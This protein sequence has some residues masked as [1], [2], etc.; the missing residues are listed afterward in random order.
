MERRVNYREL[1]CFHRQSEKERNKQYKKDYFDLEQFPTEQMQ[2]EVR[3]FL[4]DSGKTKSFNSMRHYFTYLNQ[5]ARFLHIKKN[6]GIQSLL[7]QPPEKWISSLKGW[8][9]EEGKPRTKERKSAYGNT[10]ILDADLILFFKQIL[11]YLQP[12][13]IRDEIEKDV[14]ELDKLEIAVRENPIYHVKTISFEKIVQP[15]MR[16]EIK[17][18]IYQHLSCEAIATIQREL[19]SF[20]DFSGFLKKKFPEVESCQDIDRNV[21][22]AYLIHKMTDGK[23]GKGNS[24]TILKLRA[25]LET[26]GKIY[27]YDHLETLFLNT[28]IPPE[29]QPEF[30]VYSDREMETL[31]AHIIQ[32]DEQIARCMIIHQM[33]GTRISDTLTLRTDCIY[34]TGDQYMIQ[35]HQVKTNTYTKPISYELAMLLEQSIEYTKN[36]YGKTK[37]IF[38]DEKD[39]SRPLR[40]NTLKSK[41]LGMIRKEELRDDDGKLFGFGTHMFRHYY[42]VQLTELHLDDWTV[43]RLLGHKRL[44]SVQHYRKMSNQLIADESRKIREKLTEIIFDNLDGWG[45]EY[46]QIR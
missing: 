6:Q 11:K 44:K 13:D 10:L 7:N 17:K 4:L 41:V 42:G 19:S 34:M 8:M 16:S 33:L 29:W 2:E 27:S 31:N 36:R 28:D 25:V 18:A 24:D 45:E 35:I 21:W 22:E 39:T 37:Y 23:P 5:I 9:L 15:D 32:M 3:D 1:E 12:E 43:A 20:R 38:V 14:W 40:Y 26:V 46:E 30:K